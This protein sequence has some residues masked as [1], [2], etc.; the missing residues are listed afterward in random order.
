M[1]SQG[2]RRVSAGPAGTGHRSGYEGTSGLARAFLMIESDGFDIFYHIY[3][4][5]YIAARQLLSVRACS[6]A[7]AQLSC[8]CDGVTATHV[9]LSM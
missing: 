5:I 7:T 2:R 6:T 9:I 4:Y 3:I 8:C 1:M